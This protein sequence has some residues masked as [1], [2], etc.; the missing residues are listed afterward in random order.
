LNKKDCFNNNF[1][2][3]FFDN[4]RIEN[5][6]R[7]I[8]IKSYKHY[9]V[10]LLGKNVISFQSLPASFRFEQYFS[11]VNFWTDANFSK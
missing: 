4:Y 2:N 3:I 5:I 9:E 1:L 10:L 8:S 6:Q 7:G 11:W